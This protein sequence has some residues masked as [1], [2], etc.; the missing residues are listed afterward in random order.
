MRNNWIKDELLTERKLEEYENDNTSHL[1]FDRNFE[2]RNWYDRYV[3]WAAV[4]PILLIILF[5][6]IAFI[7]NLF[8]TT[9][10]KFRSID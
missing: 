6:F 5:L 8:V 7:V 3:A 10:P 9:Q 1:E 4:I 2:N